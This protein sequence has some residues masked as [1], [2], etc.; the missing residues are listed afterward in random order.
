MS[1]A[2]LRKG[3]GLWSVIALGLGTAVG[4]SI[5]SVLAPATAVAGPAMLLSVALAA[6]PMFLIAIPYAFMG[7]ALPTAGAS[8]E[9]T[10]RFISPEIGFATSWL[11]IV[12]STGAM[13][14]LALVLVRYASMIIP[15]PVKP[16]MLVMYALVFSLNLL[17]VGVAA[18][19]QTV[20]MGVLLAVFAVFIVWGAPS[21]QRQ[22]FVPFMPEGWVGAL[23]AVP[24]LVGLFFGIEAATEVGDEVRDS[25]RAIPIGIAASMLAAIALYLLMAVTALGVLGPQA[26][27][28]SETPLLDAAAVFMGQDVAK[29]V[30]VFAAVAAITKSLNSLCLIFSRYLFAM[31]RAGALPAILSRVHPRFGTPHVALATAF[32]FCMLGLLLPMNLTSLFLAVNIPSM[33]QSI[34]ICLA[35]AVIAKKHPEIYAQARFKLGKRATVASAW[36]GVASALFVVALGFTTDWKP[37]AALGVWGLVGLVFY[38]ATGRAKTLRRGE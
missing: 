13:L 4:V 14:I 34:A 25:R 12:S 20:L 38:V 22:S 29:L 19:V 28:A 35:A 31:G 1:Q 32:G 37:Y 15:M 17:G 30:I 27:A 33:I 21:I 10:R 3:V 5:F 2:A 7:S 24:L 9:W 18:R 16:A 26:L 36:V 8:F 11:R 6:V 23:A